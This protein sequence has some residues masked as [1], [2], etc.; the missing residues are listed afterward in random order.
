[1]LSLFTY[2]QKRFTMSKVAADWQEPIIPQHTMRLSIA[3]VSEQLEWRF[4]A[5]RH[6]T[7]LISYTKPLLRSPKLLFISH[8]TS[9]VTLDG[10]VITAKGTNVEM[11]EDFC[12]LGSYIS[13]TGSCDKECMVRIGKAAS[14]FGRLSNI[15]KNKN[16]RLTVKI[17]LY[18]SLVISTLL[19]GAESW[20]LSVTQMKKLEAAHHKFQKRLL[21][22]T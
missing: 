15:W 17:R 14:S 10:T 18:E 8:P 21:G 3:R 4:A 7:A 12:Y 2:G 9:T 19:Y 20:P 16:I 5:S 13:R 22:I 1:L 11:V 6:T